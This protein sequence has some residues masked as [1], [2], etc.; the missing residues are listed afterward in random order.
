MSLSVPRAERGAEY[1]AAIMVFS[2]AADITS[3]FSPAA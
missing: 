3:R 1:V 2:Q